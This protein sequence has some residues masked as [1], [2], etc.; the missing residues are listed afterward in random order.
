MTVIYLY[1]CMITTNIYH[2]LCMMTD[3]LKL[4]Q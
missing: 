4:F 1:E 2:A 3:E